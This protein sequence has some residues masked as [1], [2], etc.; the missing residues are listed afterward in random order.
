MAYNWLGMNKSEKVLL[1]GAVSLGIAYVAA[2]LEEEGMPVQVITSEN[3]IFFHKGIFDL[4]IVQQELFLSLKNPRL[5][6]LSAYIIRMLGGR[7]NLT[8]TKVCKTFNDLLDSTI[9]QDLIHDEQIRLLAK[10]NSPCAANKLVL[11]KLYPRIFANVR[12]NSF[13][14]IED[15]LSNNR[16]RIVGV[17]INAL[18]R[19]SSFELI[20]EI[21]AQY[22]DIRIVVG[23]IH[24]TTMY[25]QILRQYPYGIAVLGEGEEIMAELVSS[26]NNGQS[27]K[28]VKGIA[29][30]DAEQ[31]RIVCTP[32]REIVEQLDSFPFPDHRFIISREDTWIL[33]SRGCP[34]HC[35]F[36]CR[37]EG[38]HKQVRY[39]SIL[40]IMQELEYIRKKF[41]QVKK[42]NIAD[43]TFFVDPQRVIT[44]CDEV[45]RR[46]FDFK[47]TCQGR[48]KPLSRQMVEKL[49]QAGFVKVEL[50]VESANDDIRRRANK[51]ISKEDILQAICLFAHTSIDVRI[52]L[53]VGLPGETMTTIRETGLFVQKLQKIKYMFS[54]VPTTAIAYPGTELYLD[55]QRNGLVKSDSWMNDAKMSL[56]YTAE[57]SESELFKMYAELGSYINLEYFFTLK[58]FIRQL[59]VVLF[60]SDWYKIFRRLI[61]TVCFSRK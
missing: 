9:Y 32:P 33:T 10:F 51:L 50:G 36:C 13:Y 18:D 6:R 31:Q 57:H 20:E 28:D 42:V 34:C 54:L 40:N 45:M 16:C 4:Q 17:Q 48:V 37:I 55:M 39:R 8:L 11:Q 60:S 7:K 12:H 56:L 43:D 38:I 23:G 15:F 49:A 1:V 14:L 5:K 58:G 35:S 53:I 25:E 24:A 3:T 27:L 41:P 46:K 2:F 52:G 30:F 19:M 61:S 26:L 44:F 47:F 22:P 29:F 21:H 59:P